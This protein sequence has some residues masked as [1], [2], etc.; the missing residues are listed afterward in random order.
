MA[1]YLAVN[2]ASELAPATD[3]VD[4][5]SNIRQDAFWPWQ[6]EEIQTDNGTITEYTP[7]ANLAETL[8]TLCLEKCRLGSS[9]TDTI[10]FQAWNK[11][12]SDIA[13]K[14]SHL[15]TMSRKV[16]QSCK[17]LIFK[18]RW[19]QLLTYKL[20]HRY[21]LVASPMCPGCGQPDG[22]HHAISACPNLSGAAAKR[23]NDGGSL[24]IKELCYGTRSSE[25]KMC[26]VGLSKRSSI[27]RLK[28]RIPPTALPPAMPAGLRKRVS[29]RCKPDALLLKIEK[30][31]RH[32]EIVEI[33]YCRDTDP[34][35]QEERAGRQHHRLVNTIKQFDEKAQVKVTTIML[36]V[37]GCIYNKTI[38]QLKALGIEQRRLPALLKALHFSAVHHLEKIWRTRA[39]MITACTSVKSANWSKRKRDLLQPAELHR[40]RTRPK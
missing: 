12:H 30:G 9:N 14:Y 35:Q 33:K 8:K 26:D 36:G 13:H 38:E 39:A 23:H 18:Y 24:I 17:R 5:P 4:I 29:Q 22:G 25:L 11:I 15:F 19:G 6:K 10:Y 1:D 34:S 7:L 28:S 20:L 31:V 37:S 32:Y 16:A 21:N 2:V 3:S 27:T 40:K